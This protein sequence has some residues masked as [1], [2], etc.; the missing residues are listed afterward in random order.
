MEDIR[1][2]YK[3]YQAYGLFQLSRVEQWFFV[4]A[5]YAVGAI[6][7][8]NFNWWLFILLS[9]PYNLSVYWLDAKLEQKHGKGNYEILFAPFI[10][11]L[12]L[13]LGT[14]IL[15]T[16]ELNLK[17]LTGSYLTYFGMNTTHSIGH[18]E[19]KLYWA[20]PAL[21]TVLAGSYLLSNL[22]SN[23]VFFFSCLVL[24]F[25]HAVLLLT[26]NWRDDC[27]L[28]LFGCYVGSALTSVIVLCLR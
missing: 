24:G 1:I 5:S 7:Y 14:G 13:F 15:P 12:P 4:S 17:V 10:Y 21:F 2:Q 16:L 9:F 26:K 27:W 28:A 23:Y 3:N 6:Y 25:S 18:K 11:M 19:V 20:Y 8:N 22:V